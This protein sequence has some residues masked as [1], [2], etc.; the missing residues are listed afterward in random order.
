MKM[1]RS[2]SPRVWTVVR[3]GILALLVAGFGS[4]VWG[5][6]LV[7]N[8]MTRPAIPW[9]VPAMAVVLWLMWQYLDGRWW[10]RGTSAARHRLLRA[11][12]VP[13]RVFAWAL[14]AGGLSL[15]ALVGLWIVLVELTKVGG[16]PTI[17]NA[18]AYP[19]LTVALALIMGSLVS[20]LTEEAAFRGYCQVTLERTF[21]GVT[22]IAISSVFFALWHGPTQGFLWPKLLFYFLVGVVFGAAAYLTNS[23][24]PAIPV[25]IAGDLTFFFLVWPHDATRPFVWRDGADAWFWISVAQVV[26]FAALAALAFRR[27]ARSTAGARAGEARSGA[28]AGGPLRTD[29]ET[30]GRSARA[31]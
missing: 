11:R 31:R 24:L 13:G 30:D 18:S 4:V 16:N 21:R 17:P 8:L 29:G 27:L 10:P 1:M 23:V 22:A 3:S 6:L 5:A 12:R 25:H 2:L 14:V 28:P 20:P 19:Q 9:A 15:V 7:G 26:I